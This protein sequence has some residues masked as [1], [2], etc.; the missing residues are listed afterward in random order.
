MIPPP[1]L[2][3][4]G[5]PAAARPDPSPVPAPSIDACLSPPQAGTGEGSAAEP[6]AARLLRVVGA[7]GPVPS[8]V[9]L[10]EQVL[11]MARS[12]EVH[13]LAVASA[14]PG[15]CVGFSHTLGEGTIA[16]LVLGLEYCKASLLAEGG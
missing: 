9:A 8:V 14:H 6:A 11:E 16:D 2:R 4:E 12:G 13:A 10:A 3:V 15:R 5:L 7:P 1:W